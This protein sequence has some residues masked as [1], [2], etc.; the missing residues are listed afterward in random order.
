VIEPPPGANAAVFD[1][2]SASLTARRARAAFHFYPRTV[3][4]S[5]GVIAMLNHWRIAIGRLLEISDV[6]RNDFD[7]WQ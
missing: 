2:R 4:A 1:S 7:H 5:A 6:H 3:M